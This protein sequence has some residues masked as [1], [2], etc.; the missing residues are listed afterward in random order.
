GSRRLLR[1]N[2]DPEDPESVLLDLPEG[3]SKALPAALDAYRA[4]LLDPPPAAD[5]EIEDAAR[6][7]G[8]GVASFPRVRALVLV[9]GPT[10]APDDD[11]ILEV[12]ELSDA[13]LLP[14]APP[15]VSYDSVQDRV[16]RTS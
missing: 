15:D 7:K 13:V 16:L 9:R 8:S 1:G 14:H 6:E 10:S 5:F 2:I 11:V 4:T 3:F 12:K